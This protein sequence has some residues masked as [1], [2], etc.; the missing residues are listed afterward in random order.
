M[1]LGRARG[2]VAPMWPD[3][4]TAI[5]NSSNP[6]GILY[7][8]SEWP[9]MLLPVAV[10]YGRTSDSTTRSRRLASAVPPPAGA[11][12]GVVSSRSRWSLLWA[13]PVPG[14]RRR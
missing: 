5:L 12:P 11:G 2:P 4:V 10:W 7:G 3:Y 13:S 1:C 8:F 14:R 6:R 9:M